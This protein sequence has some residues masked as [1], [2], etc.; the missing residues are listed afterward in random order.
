MYVFVRKHML[1]QAPPKCEIPYFKMPFKR[2]PVTL[3]EQ[4]TVSFYEQHV[5]VNKR[6]EGGG[7]ERG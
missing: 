4:W 5:A 7:W 6:P 3:G 1:S 2:K